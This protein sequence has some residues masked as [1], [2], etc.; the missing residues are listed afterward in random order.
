MV[1]RWHSTVT[2]QFVP[3]LVPQEHGLHLDTR[4]AALERDGGT[5]GVLIGAV[6]PSSLAVSVS[7]FS[8]DDLWRARDLT[9][10][11]PRAETI[12]HVDAADRGLGTLSCGP[13]VLPEYRVAPG[14]FTWRW[15]L[16]AYDPGRD[17]V[18]SLA[19]VRQSVPER[20]SHRSTLDP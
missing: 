9:E 2:D 3:Y 8:D 6:N 18:G 5:D 11:V 4:W 19:R 16:R 10:L 14:R 15:R 1:G 7:H 12:V 20:E 13:D 17:D